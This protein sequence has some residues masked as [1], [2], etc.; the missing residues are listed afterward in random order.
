MRCLAPI[1]QSPYSKEERIWGFGGAKGLWTP[2]FLRLITDPEQKSSLS[3]APS[4]G[5]VLRAGICLWPGHWV[6][7]PLWERMC[8]L[9]PC[10]NLWCLGTWEWWNQRWF[11]WWNQ[12]TSPGLR[13]S[14]PRCLQ[15]IRVCFNPLA[16]TE[17][18]RHFQGLTHL[19][20]FRN[21][22]GDETNCIP[23]GPFP[24]LPLWGQFGWLGQMQIPAL[25]AGDTQPAPTWAM[26]VA[27][28]ETKHF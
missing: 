26:A 10:L 15:Q 19:T 12:P 11:Q 20:C 21:V 17:R 1:R 16:V 22:P 18:S 6:F 9:W 2:F 24:L 13:C 25:V 23:E 4:E 27:I 28:L 5:D 3:V 14:A 8:L 7:H